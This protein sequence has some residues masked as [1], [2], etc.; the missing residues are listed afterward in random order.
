M[1][2]PRRFYLVAFAGTSERL[3]LRDLVGPE[4]KVVGQ[5]ARLARGPRFVKAEGAQRA[6]LDPEW[7]IPIVR[8]APTAKEATCLIMLD[9]R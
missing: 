6:P 4:L 9:S 2:R 8:R 7:D 1:A 3:L 5:P